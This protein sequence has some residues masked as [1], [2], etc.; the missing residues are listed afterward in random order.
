M[1]RKTKFTKADLN[2]ARRF[3]MAL[4]K[5]DPSN[6]HSTL[7][8]S[9]ESI[10]KTVGRMLKLHGTVQTGASRTA[11]VT[12]TLVFKIDRGGYVDAL[13]DECEKIESLRRGPFAKHFPLTEYVWVSP[14]ASR[15][16]GLQLQEAISRKVA[17][18]RELEQSANDFGYDIGMEDVHTGNFGWVKSRHSLYPVYFDFDCGISTARSRQPWEKY[19]YSR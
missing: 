19:I 6:T 2:L 4:L 11:F 16:G 15:F 1:T 7:G 5:L 9:T 18:P 13:E 17:V 12:D 14:F 8:P 10:F 3:G